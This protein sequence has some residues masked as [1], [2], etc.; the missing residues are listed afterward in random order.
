MLRLTQAVRATAPSGRNV[1]YG[2]MDPADL[3]VLKVP[4]Y[5][6]EALPVHSVEEWEKAFYGG[7][8]PPL[9]LGSR[10]TWVQPSGVGITIGGDE[11]YI[12]DGLQRKTTAQIILAKGGSLF[13]PVQVY[14]GTTRDWELARF[15]TLNRD[16]RAVNPSVLLRNVNQSNPAVAVMYA[17][18]QPGAGTL[19][20]GRVQWSQSP[21]KG[22]LFSAVTLLRVV[23]TLHSRFGRGLQDTD[24]P[25]LAW[26]LGDVV[27]D[28]TADVFSENLDT[29][30]RTLKGIYD[31]GKLQRSSKIVPLRLGYML[32]MARLFAGY[33]DFWTGDRLRV[34][35]AVRN[36]LAAMQFDPLEAKA[37]SN[38]GRSIRGLTT[39]MAEAAQGARRRELMP[40][41]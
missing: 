14:I 35:D 4:D 3:G 21:V 9:D 26:G 27:E 10:N 28:V 7:E 38:S 6:R 22:N 20:G 36:G 5:Q 30:F 23:A 18:T 40:W 32:S 13:V 15:A 29:F 16:R 31:F 19:L 41:S 25:R 1:V 17:Y 2:I 34:S 24:V 8:V 37:V 33:Q 12:I 11:I 39:R